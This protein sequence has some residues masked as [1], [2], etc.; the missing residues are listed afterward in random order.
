MLLAQTLASSIRDILLSSFTKLKLGKQKQLVSHFGDSSIKL[1]SGGHE[2]TINKYYDGATQ[3]FID[4]KRNARVCK[5]KKSF[6]ECWLYHHTFPT[7]ACIV[8][9]YHWPVLVPVRIAY[10]TDAC[11][12]RY[13]YHMRKRPFIVIA[14]NDNKRRNLVMLWYNDNKLQLLKSSC[15]CSFFSKEF[16]AYFLYVLPSI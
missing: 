10:L 8:K 16:E 15:L 11:K 5:N 9:W 3:N 12:A 7:W 14:I 4:R 6:L 1:L 13:V 2:T